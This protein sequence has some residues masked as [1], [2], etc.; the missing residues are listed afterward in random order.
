MLLLYL[1]CLLFPLTNTFFQL[2]WAS[3]PW[4]TGKGFGF[5]PEADVDGDGIP[6]GE[7][8]GTE[9]LVRSGDGDGDDKDDGG[10]P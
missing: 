10:P 3:N 2:C 9:F 7:V 6:D 1:I 4:F 8:T 5:N